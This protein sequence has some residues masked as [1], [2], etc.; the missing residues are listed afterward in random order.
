[1]DVE[2]ISES[3]SMTTNVEKAII[4]VYKRFGDRLVDWKVSSTHG[5]HYLWFVIRKDGGK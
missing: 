3:F 4:E 5:C 1:M 2:V